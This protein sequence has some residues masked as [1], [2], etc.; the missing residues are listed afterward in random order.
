MKTFLRELVKLVH[1][2]SNQTFRG[3]EA[4][5]KLGIFYKQLK[6][7][8]PQLKLSVLPNL[9]CVLFLVDVSGIIKYR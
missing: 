7:L 9:K 8:Q 2:F 6:I 3:E 4:I 5:K 1:K